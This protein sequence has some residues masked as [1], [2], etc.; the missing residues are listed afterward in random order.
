[1]ISKM[2]ADNFIIREYRKGDFNGVSHLWIITDLGNPTRG[3]DESIIEL[4][5]PS[6][7]HLG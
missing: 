2:N 6:A 5:D 4:T 3:D 1:M 7:E